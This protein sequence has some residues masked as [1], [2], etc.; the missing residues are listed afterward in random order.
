[1]ADP[2]KLNLV[3]RATNHVKLSLEAI[4]REIFA[5]D[6]VPEAFQYL[7]DEV[8]SKVRIFRGFPNR[9]EAYP[10]IAITAGRFDG[11]LIA[12]GSKGEEASE[13]F[14]K[15]GNLLLAETFTGFHTIPITLKVFSKNSSDERE[16]LF[17]LLYC[18]IRIFSLN[19]LAAFGVAYNKIYINGEDQVEYADRELIFTNSVTIECH[20]DFTHVVDIAQEDLINKI[21]IRVFGAAGGDPKA[22]QFFE[23]TITP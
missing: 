1:M 11:S 23:E 2:K 12:M 13:V 15:E 7:P 3:F 17:D 6:L 21:V 22:T 9:K 19:R 20:T 18:I 16:K 4:L 5:T 10:C 8:A 14:N